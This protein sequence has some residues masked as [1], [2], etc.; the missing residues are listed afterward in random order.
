MQQSQTLRT[1]A[2]RLLGLC[3]VGAPLKSILPCF[4]E[5]GFVF[6]ASVTLDFFHV[7][8]CWSGFSAEG[9]GRTEKPIREKQNKLGIC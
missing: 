8:N 4:L 5:I 6:C 9:S 1:S 7:E 3:K 2:F